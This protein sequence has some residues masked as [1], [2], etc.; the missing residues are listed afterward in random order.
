[1]RRALLIVPELLGD[2]ER[3][4]PLR[5][6]LPALRV[7]AELG[8]IRK[9]AQM[10][11]QETPEALFLGARPGE[12]ALRPGP[13][14]VSALNADPPERSIHFH[15]SLLAFQE[16]QVGEIPTLP[17]PEEWRVVL[18][19]ARR[20]DTKS[21]TLV[22]GEGKDHG[23]V[24][25]GKG[26]L[27]TRPAAEAVGQPLR[28][29]LPEGDH[30][31]ALRRYIDDSINLLSELEVN[32]RRVDEGLAPLNL[33]W[34]WGHGVR[35]SVPNLA[36]RRG[37]PVTVE[38]SSFRLA[39][40]ARLTGD[41]HEDR[42]VFGRG[43][44]TRLR[45]LADRILRRDAT[46]AVLDAPAMLRAEGEAREEELH[47]FVREMDRELLQPLLDS[48]LIDPLR[49]AVIAPGVKAEGLALMA[50]PP[51]SKSGHYPFD[52]RAL[53]ER[54]IPRIDVDQAVRNALS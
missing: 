37:E 49:I 12:I 38:S 23:L 36:L 41:S 25:E 30:E 16:G 4:S 7:L 14:I 33:L 24:L 5:Q 54:S 29:N 20:L 15:L 11:R 50:E 46:I 8:E 9:L 53:E 45:G 48:T 34:P 39:G 43:L 40:L 28:G 51:A 22:A 26:D 1:V 6:N 35:T 21:L 3:E 18:E 42:A 2:P 17:T 44:Q 47:W 31:N 32:Q 13:L 19:A 10:P 27:G 52:E